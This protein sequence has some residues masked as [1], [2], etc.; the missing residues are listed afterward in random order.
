MFKLE[1]EIVYGFGGDAIVDRID[2]GDNIVILCESEIGEEFWLLL[3]E[4][5][6]HNVIKTFIDNY[7]NTYYEGDEVICGPWYDI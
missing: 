2:V 3:C 7:K 5:T 6:K 1:E 4:K